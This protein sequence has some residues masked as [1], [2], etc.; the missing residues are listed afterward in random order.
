MPQPKSLFATESSS[1]LAIS[2]VG[3]GMNAPIRPEQFNL[4]SALAKSYGIK[5]IV[6]L[7]VFVVNWTL[8]F[9]SL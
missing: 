5:G 2:G 8:V 7:S 3:G 9:F 6:F 4:P 1:K